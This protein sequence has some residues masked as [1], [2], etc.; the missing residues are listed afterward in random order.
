M[1]LGKCHHLFQDMR[2]SSTEK[3]KGLWFATKLLEQSARWILFY[4]CWPLGQTS[5]ESPPTAHPHTKPPYIK[6]KI[7]FLG[8]EASEKNDV[9]T[10]GYAHYRRQASWISHE[11]VLHKRGERMVLLVILPSVT[12]GLISAA[13]GWMLLYISMTCLIP[14]PSISVSLTHTHNMLTLWQAIGA[15]IAYPWYQLPVSYWAL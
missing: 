11:V 7:L 2:N 5:N 1:W 15:F 9:C 3:M 10:I 4:C 12:Q 6:T 8:V 13:S 14:C